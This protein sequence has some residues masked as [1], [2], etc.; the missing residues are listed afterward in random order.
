LNSNPRPHQ[1]ETY[2]GIEL[3]QWRS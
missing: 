1:L 3:R 2:S